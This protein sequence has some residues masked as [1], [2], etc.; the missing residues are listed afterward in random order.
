MAAPSR[1]ISAIA[2]RAMRR[3]RSSKSV[4]R[5]C[6]TRSAPRLSG[7][8]EEEDRADRADHRADEREQQCVYTT[9]ILRDRQKHRAQPLGVDAQTDRE[10]ATIQAGEIRTSH[11]L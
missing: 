11:T 4:T 6:T 1:P 9:E 7:N 10:P 5:L 3:M 8:R 2:S